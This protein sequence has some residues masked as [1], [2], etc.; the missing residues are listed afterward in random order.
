M[1]TCR[2]SLKRCQDGLGE[3]ENTID[4]LYSEQS[5][6]NHQKYRLR[7]EVRDLQAKV[8]VLELEI[9]GLKSELESCEDTVSRAY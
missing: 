9:K 2:A 8:I 6:I 1:S 4:E 3:K 7:R 5:K